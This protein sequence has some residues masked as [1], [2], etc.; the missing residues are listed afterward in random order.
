MQINIRQAA[1]GID[2][3]WTKKLD[4]YDYILQFQEQL[5]LILEDNT[6]KIGD[7]P[8]GNWIFKS[9]YIR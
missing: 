2:K 8:T 1:D 3:T 9:I 7:A 6:F 4:I 5:F